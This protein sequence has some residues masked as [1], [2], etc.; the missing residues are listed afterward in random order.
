M[1]LK[2]LLILLMV[3]SMCYAQYSNCQLYEAYITRDMSVWEHY[4]DSADWDSLD[5]EQ[6]KQLLNYEY[7]FSAYMLGI[8]VEK[9]KKLIQ[10]FATHLE[11]IKGELQEERYCAYLASVYTYQLALNRGQLV[12]YAKR[13]FSN[14]E[15]AM[16]L[17]PNDPFVLSMQGNVEFYSPFGNKKTALGYYQKADSLYGIAGADYERWN[18]RAVQLT[19]IQCLDKQRRSDEAIALCEKLLAEEPNNVNF[20]QLLEDLRATN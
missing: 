13:I 18:R 19:Y 6:R 9:S 16:E 2:Y 11:A 4:I 10:R 3:S 8:D 20:Q 7:G 12:K 15:R 1:K 14:I 5:T 17:N